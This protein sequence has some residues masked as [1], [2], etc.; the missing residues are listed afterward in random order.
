MP[1]A[2]VVVCVIGVRATPVHAPDEAEAAL[3][4]QPENVMA[5]ELAVEGQDVPAVLTVRRRTW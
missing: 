3:A 1:V 4:V 2:P 5:T